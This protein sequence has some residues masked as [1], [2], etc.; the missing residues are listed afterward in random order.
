MRS[1]VIVRAATGAAALAL[2]VTACTSSGGT[3]AE[4]ALGIVSSMPSK[5]A[6]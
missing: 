3:A 2:A 1:S 6:S 5:F 4:L